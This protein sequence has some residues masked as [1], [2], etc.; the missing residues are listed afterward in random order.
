[1]LG[2][3]AFILVSLLYMIPIAIIILLAFDA[4]WIKEKKKRIIGYIIVAIIGVCANVM[5]LLLVH[6]VIQKSWNFL[7]TLQ[8]VWDV[9]LSYQEV[10][11][12][13]ISWGG[14]LVVSIGLGLVIRMVLYK[15]KGDVYTGFSLS[16]YKKAIFVLLNAVLFG[17]VLYSFY[18]G[19]SGTQNI[20]ISEVDAELE[21][22]EIYN[23]GNLA[24]NTAG[25]YLSD[26]VNDLK[27]REVPFVRLP[28]K[29]YMVIYLEK[30]D[31]SIKQDGGETIFLSEGENDIIDQITTLATQPGMTT[32]RV[33]E[34]KDVVLIHRSLDDVNVEVIEET[35]VF[36]QD[37]GFYEEEFF[38]SLESPSGYEI[39]YTLD[40]S[41]PTTESLCYD[42][43]IRIYNRSGEP[44][45][46]RSEKRV[47]ENWNDYVPDETPVDKA[48]VVRAIVVDDRGVAGNVVTKT[49]FVDMEEYQGVT[50]ISLVADPEDMWGEDGIYVTGAEYDTWY[51]GDQTGDAPEENFNK[52][53]REYEVPASFAYFS[54]DLNFEQTIGLRISGAAARGTA[55]KRFNLYARGE[56]SG[57][58]VFEENI[59]EGISSHR[60]CLREGI[61][62]TLCQEIV[63]DRYVATQQS[64]R[65]CVFLNGEF[66]YNTY[67]TEKYDARFFEQHF[68]L[69]RDD[70]VVFNQGEIK[71]GIPEDTEM[72]RDIH[73]Y[74]TEHD[75]S[76][77]AGYAGFGELVDIQSYIDYMCINVY[78]DNMDFTEIKNTIVWRSKE[79]KDASYEDGKWRYCLYDLDAMEWNDASHWNI[80]SQAQKNSFS[81]MPKYTAEV[82][83]NQQEMFVNLKK[84]NVFRKQ[85]VL[86]FMDLV[87]TN[88]KYDKVEDIIAEYET[89]LKRYPN[90]YT[91]MNYYKEFF[92]TRANY[93]VKYLA[94]EFDLSGSLETLTIG[95]ND[96]NGGNVV[97]NTISPDL[98]EGSWSGEYY[99]DY[100]VTVTAVANPGYEFVGWTGS[101]NSKE[102]TI[103][104]T[105]GKGGARLNAIFKKIN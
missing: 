56:Y 32:G 14:S 103:E 21:C 101:N 6:K 82:P 10:I 38:L 31:F 20:V 9:N 37:G 41:I 68:G 45:V 88:F 86:T 42:S 98:E 18:L 48:F 105:L 91:N 102:A 77:E 72:Y 52:H 44:N 69:N 79:D 96:T 74:L 89:E 81:L 54:E 78:I 59:F 34:F 35:P 16:N 30:D 13:P 19:F 27:K 2:K 22:I 93:I 80:E 11:F 58:G 92:S 71:E 65:L 49:Y 76:T 3:C 100:P 85:F 17:G 12:F 4:S 33:N 104:L 26:N 90:G 46:Y 1:M 94:E 55:L 50:V 87:N 8:F 15:I 75:L 61:A 97:V 60:L 99:T 40:G 57:S 53:G 5:M 24:C 23:R 84:N 29:T 63:R 47:V 43:P 67:I 95:I 51:L 36:S 28:A 83:I 70:V 39:Y 25:M 7:Q 64:K 73:R 66:W 62:N